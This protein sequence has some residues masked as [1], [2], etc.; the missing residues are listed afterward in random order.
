MHKQGK[1]RIFSNSQKG[2]VAGVPGCMEHAVMTRELMTHAIE[3]KRDLYMIQIDFTNAFGSVPHGLIK[4]NRECMG[5]PDTQIQ[6]I[7]KI[8]EG[9][10]TVF[11]VPTGG[12]PQLHGEVEQCKAAHFHRHYSTSAWNLFY[13]YWKENNSNN[14]ALK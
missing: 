6:T 4:Y 3:G 9:A 5:L 14:M 7:M 8:Y 11:T 2:F 13:G 12:H 10:T 1:L